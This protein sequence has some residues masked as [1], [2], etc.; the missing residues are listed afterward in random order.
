MKRLHSFSLFSAV[1][2]F[3]CAM[4]LLSGAVPAQAAEFAG[5]RQWSERGQAAVLQ[6]RMRK[7]AAAQVPDEVFPSSQTFG[8]I[9]GPDGNVW[10]YTMDY[11]TD[12]LGF[13]TSVEVKIYDATRQLKGTFKDT[14]TLREGDRGVNFVQLNPLVTKKFFNSDDKYEVMLFVHVVTEDYVGRFYNDAFSI[15][16]DGNVLA[17]IEGNESCAVDMATDQWMEDYYMLFYEESFETIQVND[18]TEDEKYYLNF[19]VYKKGG[20]ASPQPVLLHTFKIDYEH[21]AASGNEPLPVY[22]MRN[23]NQLVFATA[24]YEKPYFDPE[25][26]FWEDPVVTPDNNLVITLY[27]S[28]FQQTIQTKIPVPETSEYIYTFPYMGGFRSNEDITFGE[29]D[30]TT[31]P[32]F[33]ITFDDYTSA[34]DFL[35]S[36]YLYNKKGERIGTIAEETMGDIRMSEI[37]GQ[38]TQWCF[39][40]TV[41]QETTFTFIDMPSL[42]TVAQ[43]PAVI[44]GLSLTTSMDRTPMGDGYNYVFSMAQGASNEKGEVIHSIAWFNRDGSFSHYDD[45]N[46]GSKVVMAQAYV[47]ADALDPWL[48]STADDAYEYMVLAKESIDE[49]SSKTEEHLYVVNT[50]GEKLLDYAPV[51]SLGG[52]LISIYLLNTQTH[53]TLLCVRSNMQTDRRYTMNFTDLPLSA[54]QGGDG[55]AANP[56]LIATAGD[57]KQIDHAPTAHYSVVDDVDFMGIPFTGLTGN[58]SGVLRGNDHV[59]SNLLLSKGGLFKTVYPD[60]QIRDLWIDR[61]TVLLDGAFTVGIVADAVMGNPSGND[62]TTT[63]SNIH[64]T[65]PRVSGTSDIFGGIAGAANLYALIEGSSVRN[66]DFDLP[67][68][69]V[70]GIVG[71]TSTSVTVRACSFSGTINGGQQVGGIVADKSAAGDVVENCHVNAELTGRGHV[72]GIAG[73][74]G[75]GK[76]R[77]C[78]TEGTVALHAESKRG[79]VGGLIGYLEESSSSGEQPIIVENNLV[80]VDSIGF[81]P[82]AAADDV[83]AHRVIGRSSAD[84]TTYDWEHKD[85]NGNYIKIFIGTPDKGLAH[86]YAIE[87]LALIDA[88]VAD[89]DSTTEGKTIAPEDITAEWLGSRNFLFGDSIAQPWLLTEAS[90][91]MWFESLA[92]AFY[93]N[94]DEIMIKVGQKGM[95]TLTVVGGDAEQI[96]LEWAESLV[97]CSSVANGEDLVVTIEAISV[98]TT[99]LKATYG[100]KTLSVTITI[101]EVMTV[102]NVDANAV[103]RVRKEVR[104]GQVVIVCDGKV[105]SILGVALQ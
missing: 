6:H 24:F 11:T 89:N 50:N 67:T 7:H 86:N 90:M 84:E 80:A 36:F 38:P 65:S 105:Y 71:Q 18:T 100:T 48:F 2:S 57:F 51:D 98:G 30:D 56:Y 29:F 28:S 88:A 59:F 55:T 25:I 62:S 34:D 8:T 79:S 46:L 20:Y 61:P 44:G 22:M 35:R 14:F 13:Y 1:A 32:I 52:S 94:A 40:Q 3:F 43:I 21:V 17:T 12:S 26:P 66:A 73:F 81:V 37:A 53:P 82:G 97:K 75:R 39:L 60:A 101:E 33:I 49:S 91:G 19:H 83:V 5:S 47:G 63:L 27:N 92:G 85:E 64:I 93:A 54:F 45:L 74:S 77:N 42:E 9:N 31:D 102:D 41:N 10:T 99:E 96:Q 15:G 76:I 68:A 87:D 70:G 72:G 16:G 104:N 78:F 95:V 103:T 23:G 58:F 4:T 69:E